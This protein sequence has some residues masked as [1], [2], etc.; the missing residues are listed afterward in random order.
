MSDE[1]LHKTEFLHGQDKKDMLGCN[2]VGARAKKFGFRKT[3]NTLL[4]LKFSL[5]DYCTH[6]D[7]EYIEF[8]FSSS[9]DAP[10][11]RQISSLLTFL[12]SHPPSFFLRTIINKINTT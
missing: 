12:P 2:D 6:L 3:T 8:S 7:S 9:F 4:T 1:D 11:P 5:S 10:P